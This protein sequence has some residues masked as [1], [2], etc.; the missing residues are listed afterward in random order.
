ML[1]KK[2]LPKNYCSYTE[3]SKHKSEG[4]IPALDGLFIDLISNGQS[5]Y[6][7]VLPTLGKDL[8]C[9]YNK[10]VLSGFLWRYDNSSKVKYLLNT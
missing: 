8:C 3:N 4:G 6:L 2:Y 1:C 7:P 9:S 10:G 5:T